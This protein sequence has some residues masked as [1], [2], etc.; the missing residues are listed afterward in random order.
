MFHLQGCGK[1]EVLL[2]LGEDQA[3]GEGADEVADQ[4]EDGDRS[5]RTTQFRIG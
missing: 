5:N 3:V 4:L 2:R 1:R